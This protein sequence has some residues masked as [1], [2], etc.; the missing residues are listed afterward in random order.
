MYYLKF[1][2]S[3]RF[4]KGLKYEV[5]DNTQQDFEKIL[6]YDF[7]ST[8]EGSENAVLRLFN[9]MVKTPEYQLI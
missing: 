4:I 6:K 3:L 2:I 7:D 1:K 8:T 5:D 9:A